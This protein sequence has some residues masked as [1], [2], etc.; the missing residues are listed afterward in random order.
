MLRTNSWL[1]SLLM[2]LVVAQSGR[3]VEAGGGS[4]G[5]Y[6]ITTVL[7]ALD[8]VSLNETI[9]S[10]ATSN[11]FLTSIKIGGMDVCDIKAPPYVAI[12]VIMRNNMLGNL[13]E[14][15]STRNHYAIQTIATKLYWEAFAPS[16]A[17]L[18][19]KSGID[20]NSGESGGSSRGMART[21]AR[22]MTS[23][24]ILAYA[25]ALSIDTLCQPNGMAEGGGYVF[26]G[27]GDEKDWGASLWRSIISPYYTNQM[28]SGI[29][30]LA[31]SVE[32][33]GA[34]ALDLN[35]VICFG[36]WGAKYP[37]SGTFP[38]KSPALSAI[39]AMWRAQEIHSAPAEY[40][41]F[42]DT[43]LGFISHAPF[44]DSKATQGSAAAMQAPYSPGSYIQWLHPGIP[45]SPVGEPRQSCQVL[46]VGSGTSPQVA[47]QIISEFINKTY[48]EDNTIAFAYWPR[49]V[50]CNYCAQGGSSETP[51]RHVTAEKS[52]TVTLTRKP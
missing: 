24:M 25:S 34:C 32:T 37:T 9:L 51:V 2:M 47:T 35:Y 7:G 12:C 1:L 22:P 23:S 29:S 15:S 14:S 52:F 27:E 13:M 20:D 17:P 48:I 19:K 8:D 6:G 40:Y 49:F 11:C 45:A 41:G 44:H 33:A 30:L 46:G 16:S 26:Y 36:G 43:S 3:C 18:N 21:I 31:T 10:A 38:A 42:Y 4:G 5:G 28:T 50:C 39:T